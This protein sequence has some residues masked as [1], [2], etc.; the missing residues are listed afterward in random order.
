VTVV[1]KTTVVDNVGIV[2]IV[3]VYGSHVLTSV[4]KVGLQVDTKV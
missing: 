1:V 4:L 3:S 2:I